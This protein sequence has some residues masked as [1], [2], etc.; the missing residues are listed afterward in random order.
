MDEFARIAKFFAPLA[1]LQGAFGLKDDAA[2]LEIPPGKRMVLTMDSLVESIHFM[3][4]EA[5][6]LLAQKA[7]RV[8]LSDLA[9]KGA[10]PYGYFLSLNLPERCDDHWL[11]EFACGLAVDQKLFGLSLL[12]GDTTRSPHELVITITAAGATDN[13]VR[14]S[15]AKAGDVVFVTG[16]IGDAFLGL[17]VTHG[18]L[19]PDDYL[20]G[21]YRLPEP[22]V[23]MAEAIAVH[24]NACL[25]ISDG[26]LQD[27]GHLT[28]ASGIAAHIALDTVPFYDKT[29]DMLELATGGDDYE[30]LLAAPAEAAAA[31]KR[32]AYDA[33]TTLTAI[34]VCKEGTGIHL[35][36][37][38]E[39]VPLPSRLGWMHS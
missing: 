18:L 17:Q 23:A 30:L 16:T 32:A 9:A 35:S 26:L 1:T 33:G 29:R 8:N 34:G 37:K 14:R 13:I 22:R 31:L 3:G 38:G 10:K 21:R 4:D 7:L 19:P 25:D 12:G 11:E 27:L 15:G 39:Y 2:E 28:K 36:L 20:L 24:A 5:P 6:F